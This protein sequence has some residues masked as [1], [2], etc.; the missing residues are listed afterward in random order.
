M[1]VDILTNSVENSLNFLNREF[2][3]ER[4]KAFKEYVASIASC[5][6]KYE[7][8]ADNTLWE[9]GKESYEQYR[10]DAN[11]LIRVMMYYINA[12]KTEA[13]FI[14]VTEYLKNKSDSVN[15]KLFSDSEINRFNFKKARN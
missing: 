7:K 5:K 12:V 13:D 11:E 1:I 3:Q 2:T 10:M 6:D 14:E 9:E 15:D 8:C 4:K